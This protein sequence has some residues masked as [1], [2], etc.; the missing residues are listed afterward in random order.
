MENYEIREAAA[1]QTRGNIVMLF[2]VMLVW[3]FI[4]TALASGPMIYL[5]GEVA[6]VNTF[7]AF[8]DY[9]AVFLL[10]LA[11]MIVIITLVSGIMEYGMIANQN[12]MFKRESATFSAGFSGFKRPGACI[13]TFFMRELFLL[14]W[15]LIPIAGF[16]LVFIKYYSYSCAF[17]IVQEDHS[18]GP[19]DAIT[20]SKS[21][22]DG[23][24]SQLFRLDVYYFF[25]WY[26]P[27]IFTLGIAWIWG[28]PRHMQARYNFYQMAKTEKQRQVG[29]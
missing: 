26:L 11:A 19:I 24:K 27:G 3:G 16:V 1:R 8:I 17:Y 18:E 6:N 12:R 10:F 7:E 22:M 28:V 20:K 29:N 14:L 2:L 15:L 23:K 4:M 5:V 9:I 13:S 21:I 25:V